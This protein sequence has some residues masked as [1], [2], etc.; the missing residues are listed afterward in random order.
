VK[1]CLVTRAEFKDVGSIATHIYKLSEYYNKCGHEVFIVRTN[2]NGPDTKRYEEYD[3]IKI[4]NSYSLIR[5][6]SLLTVGSNALMSEISLKKLNKE[7]CFDLIHAHE[8]AQCFTHDVITAHAVHKGWV[9]ISNNLLKS[10][11]AHNKYLMFK[12]IRY[13][14]PTNNEILAIEKYNYKKGHYKKI[15]SISNY[16][17]SQLIDYYNVPSED[18]VVIPN[19]IDCD[20]FKPDDS[21][22]WSTRK[23]LNLDDDD[24]LLLFSGNDF[25]KK[26]LKYLI[27][28]ISLIKQKNVKLVIT[29]G[30]RKTSYYTQHISKLDLNS[31][32]LYKGYV[33]DIR[34]YYN[35]A[36]IFV[37]PTLYEPFGLVITEAL[38]T[39]L[40]V[41]TSRSAGAAELITDGFEGLLLDNPT[42]SGEIAEKIC[43]LLEDKKLRDQMGTK[44]RA[45]MKKYNWD[46]VAK[47][48]LNVYEGAVKL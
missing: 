3:N 26:G 39:G 28:A 11:L 6:P 27:N 15:I 25:D 7:Y 21:V 10:K 1:I 40:P 8:G 44:G 29:G 14:S 41:I 4:F 32:I 19:G 20:K 48:T 24:I 47:K 16:M 22:R 37:F 23:M 46:F 42:D 2:W 18:I 43:V 36:D 17:K 33:S 9:R 30:D 38:S 5:K 34:D 31:R 13:A 45:T 12:F 35:A